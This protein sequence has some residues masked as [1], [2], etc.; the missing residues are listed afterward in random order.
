MSKH[1]D[2]EDASATKDIGV[3][4]LAF[5]RISLLGIVFHVARSMSPFKSSGFALWPFP[6]LLRRSDW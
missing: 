3:K 6:H 4:I 2:F 1:L 5:V